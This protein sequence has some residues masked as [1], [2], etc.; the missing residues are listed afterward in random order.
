MRFLHEIVFAS[1]ELTKDI[2]RELFRFPEECYILINHNLIKSISSYCDK[3]E[4][5]HLAVNWQ[6]MIRLGTGC[7]KPDKGSIFLLMKKVGLTDRELQHF[8]DPMTELLSYL[9][10]GK[11]FD[12]L[13]RLCTVTKKGLEKN[14]KGLARF[15]C[16]LVYEDVSA[17]IASNL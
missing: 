17:I 11:R 9:Y 3:V 5:I 1:N 14:L 4:R 2:H 12:V 6:D 7:E 13:R 16:H 8:N 10:F 15:S